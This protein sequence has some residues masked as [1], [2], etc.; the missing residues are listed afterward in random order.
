[1]P[2]EM[3]SNPDWQYKRLDKVAEITMGQSPSS[4][5][6]NNEKF[7]LPLIQGNADIYER[8]SNPRIFTSQV[9]KKCRVGDILMSV[10]APVG[11]VAKS[12]H[13]AVIGRGIAAI[14]PTVN[15]G[16]LYQYLLS[17]EGAW[18]KVSQGSTFTAINGA[19]LKKLLIPCPPL[20]EQKKIAEILST[21][22]EAIELKDKQIILK[23][24]NRN[25]YVKNV[26]YRIEKEYISQ[27]GTLKIG[28]FLIESRDRVGNDEIVPV[29]VGVNGIKL[30]TEIF[31]KE[32]SSDYSKNKI[33]RLNDICFGIGTNQIVYDVLLS[34]NVYSVS[35]A[36]RV[37]HIS[38]IDSFYL[39]CFLD[40]HNE[41]FS[42]KYMIIS[43]RQGKSVNIKGLL[44]EKIAVP[45]LKI[46]QSFRKVVVEMDSEILL[47]EKEKE[48]LAMQKQG[49]MQRLL[50]GKVRVKL[51]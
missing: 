28:S 50:T 7:G 29:A 51:D 2:N 45:P 9:T 15:E 39:K 49:L 6:Y 8:K 17:I 23:K 20:S 30:R 37:F 27:N 35:P 18:S 5:N 46:Q 10:R 25:A 43:A 47:L 1:M 3:K 24:H 12:H 34:N 32:L 44:N 36:Y 21:W 26:I 38:G 31:S 13:I 16:Y 14:R 22:D 42:K 19:E 33:I 11:T 40:T 48:L 41:I 4:K